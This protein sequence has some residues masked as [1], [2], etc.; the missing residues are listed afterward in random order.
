MTSPITSRRSVLGAIAAVPATLAAMPS[1]A[2]S[3]LTADPKWT[4]LLHDCRV[5]YATWMAT[6]DGEDHGHDAFLE[7]CA[8]L[9]PEPEK[10]GSG[11]PD[12]ISNMTIAQIKAAGDTAEHKAAWARYER[13]H[14]AWEG[15]R[16]RLREDICGPAK[17]KYKATY[18][19][20]DQAFEAMMAYRPKTSSDLCE[21]VA[22]LIESYEGCDV[23]VALLR[24]IHADVRNLA[25]RA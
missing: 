18:A 23:P 13:E 2:V 22:L 15:E 12:D 24:Y 17:A 1:S 11:L 10:P 7:A 3:P 4:A 8:N 20:Y 19:A 14:A 5:K 25:A 16:S 21:K 6:N 9:P